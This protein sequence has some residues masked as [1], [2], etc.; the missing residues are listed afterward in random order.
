M[1]VYEHYYHCSREPFRLSPDP[2]FLYASV[3]HREALA[4]LRYVVQE[5]KGFAVLT[6]EVG[7]GKT[8]LL[9][10]LLETVDTNIQSVF[11]FNPPRSVGGLYS[12]IADDLEINLGTATSPVAQLNR[13]LLKTFDN[14]ST[15]VLVFDEA[16]ALPFEVLEEIR[17]L[18]NIE[19]SNAKL[20]Q[21][22]LAGQPE[23]DAMLETR[24]LRALR[25]RLV[26]RYSLSP[27]SQADTSRYIT[28]RL[29][30]AGTQHSPFTLA[31]CDL[32]YRYSEGVPR[33]IN[34]LC[35]N[36]MLVGY[37]KGSLTIDRPEIQEVAADLRLVKPASHPKDPRPALFSGFAQTTKRHQR[38]L[39]F[40]AILTVTVVVVM[41]ATLAIATDP[42]S[43]LTPLMARV[44]TLFSHSLSWLTGAG[45]T[46]TSVISGVS[47]A[48]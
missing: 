42:P 47:G 41:L 19:T 35:D 3:P 18:T 44:A 23:L 21:V 40:A 1:A 32:V 12:A 31:A 14:G 28:S 17:L 36:A 9:R 22:I 37:A 45:G 43:S 24:E 46:Q 10:T 33:L 26:F 38:R 29:R 20:L 8:M 39:T 7:T 48:A 34:V 15:V 13:H 27:L 4:Q 6:G 11:V 2:S 30:Q 25:Q 16:H 5:R